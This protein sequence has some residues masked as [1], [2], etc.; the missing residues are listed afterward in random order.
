MKILKT[1][2]K[3]QVRL[4]MDFDYNNVY[5]RI[6]YVLGKEAVLFSDIHIKSP[7]IHWV[8]RDDAEYVMLS[9]MPSDKLSIV[10]NLLSEK[11]SYVSSVLSGDN[12]IGDH[13]EKIISYPSDEYIFVKETNSDINIVIAGWGCKLL[14]QEIKEE[15]HISNSTEKHQDEV[16][17]DNVNIEPSNTDYVEQNLHNNDVVGITSSFDVQRNNVEKEMICPKCKTTYPA[18]STY[19][20]RDGEKLTTPENLTYYCE[21][22]GTEYSS[23]TKFCPKDGGAIVCGIAGQKKCSPKSDTNITF[24]KA[25]LGSRFVASLLDGLI[26]GVLAIP[27]IVLYAIGLSNV[28]Y[29]YEYYTQDY[30][31]A[32]GYFIAAFMLYLIPLIYTFIK[33]GLGNG[34]SWGKKAMGLR[35]IKVENNSKCTKGASALRALVSTLVSMIPLVGWIIEPIMVLTTSDGRRLADKAAG[36]MVVNSK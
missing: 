2:T 11:I 15:S 9:E 30:S 14:S 28:T 34:Q 8:V 4:L 25:S 22:C 18:G 10:R 3:D 24:E 7:E 5:G 21:K 33:D 13:V 27:A 1:V 35:I 19:C 17:S 20:T 12:L 29:D 16:T 32:G 36:T 31:K 26:S 6:R 23:D